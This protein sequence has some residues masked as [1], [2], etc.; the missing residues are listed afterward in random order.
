MLHENIVY[1][2]GD[3]DHIAKYVNEP[4][5]YLSVNNWLNVNEALFLKVANWVSKCNNIEIN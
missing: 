5:K 4:K 2:M 1:L 3:Y